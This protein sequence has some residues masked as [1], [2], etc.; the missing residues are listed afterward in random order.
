MITPMLRPDLFGALASHAGDALYEQAYLRDFGKI[1]RAL[2][3]WDGDIQTWWAE[4][5]GRTSFTQPDDPLLLITLG[6]A[7]CFSATDDGTVL[8]PF[9]GVTGEVVDDVW[10]RWL[11]WDP[12]RMVPRYA[13]ALRGL[14]GIWLDAGR[15]DEWF[16]DLG[17]LAV[18]RALDRIG[19]EARVELFDGGHGGID[20][21]YP[22]S[23]E[24]L[25]QTLA[26]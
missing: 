25:A 21:R 16:L 5:R 8:L 18:G 22:M 10:Q 23:L 11:A 2:R 3:P 4:F 17:A 7:A 6:V 1:A 20:Y 13:D 9:D 24:W 14:R 26:G 19:V 12:V 15:S